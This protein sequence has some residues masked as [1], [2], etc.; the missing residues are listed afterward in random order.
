LD[1]V[2]KNSPQP[3][4][5]SVASAQSPSPPK[6]PFEGPPRS[7]SVALTGQMDEHGREWIEYPPGSDR[8][9]YR[10]IRG[11]EWTQWRD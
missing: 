7:P 11:G 1:F 8:W 4:E 5:Y 2:D 3:N 9:H 10:Q 6:H